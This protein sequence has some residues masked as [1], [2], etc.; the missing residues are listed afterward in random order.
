ML[1]FLS[2]LLDSNERELTKLA[3]LVTQ[4]NSFEEKYQKLSDDELKALGAEFKTRLLKG[5]TLDNL[6]Q[7]FVP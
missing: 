3:P 2:K 4:T 6:L 5:Q 7:G 1:P